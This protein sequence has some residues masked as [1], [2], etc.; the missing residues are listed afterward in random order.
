[1]IAALLRRGPFRWRSTQ[2]YATFS[3]APTN[4]LQCGSFH[5]STADHG[6]AHERL[7]ASAAQKAF[8]SL[9]AAL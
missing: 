1:M 9:A 4:H 6:D 5:S 7:F 8:R 2:L 3:V